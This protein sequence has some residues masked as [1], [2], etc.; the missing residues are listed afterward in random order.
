MLKKPPLD[1]VPA[2]ILKLLLGEMSLLVVEGQKVI[3]NKAINSGF[4]FR[5]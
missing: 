5:Y 3:P 2:F 1:S 4:E